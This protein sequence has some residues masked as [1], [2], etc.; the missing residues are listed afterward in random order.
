[1]FSLEDFAMTLRSKIRNAFAALAGAVLLGSV[2]GPAPAEASY[3][4]WGPGYDQVVVHR[5]GV[6]RPVVRRVVHV[7]R[8][9]YRPRPVVERVV[10]VDRPYYRPRPVVRRVVHIER[11]YYS[12]VRYSHGHGHGWRHGGWDRP[13][14]WLPER[15]LCR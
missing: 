15:H 4:G 1:M 12:R 13:R 6:H 2:A 14:C 11:P 3:R 7:H 9:Y 10:Y 8:P 5:H